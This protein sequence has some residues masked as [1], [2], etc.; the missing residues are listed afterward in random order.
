MLNKTPPVPTFITTVDEWVLALAHPDITSLQARELYGCY[1]EEES[2]GQLSPA[3]LTH[4]WPS[5]DDIEWRMF[6]ARIVQDSLATYMSRDDHE[7]YMHGET[8][9][10]DVVQSCAMFWPIF[11]QCADYMDFEYIPRSGRYAYPDRFKQLRGL[12][13]QVQVDPDESLLCKLATGTH[14]STDI[15]GAVL[16]LLD[17]ELIWSLPTTVLHELFDAA[18]KDNRFELGSENDLWLCQALSRNSNNVIEA[19]YCDAASKEYENVGPVFQRVKLITQYALENRY[20]RYMA[21]GL[22]SSMMAGN[23]PDKH[24]C[25]LRKFMKD[26]ALHHDSDALLH[27]AQVTECASEPIRSVWFV[28]IDSNVA[29]RNLND[30][31]S[32]LIPEY[33]K[34]NVA[35]DALGLTRREQLNSCLLLRSSQQELG[36]KNLPG[37]L[38]V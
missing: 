19:F 17:W 36:V 9:T 32:L 25:V 38:S 2:I 28:L 8:S 15:V 34:N 26:L 1:F 31:W 16:D 12:L 33:A 14:E 37:D 5:F 27:L 24:E 22:V 30:T 11:K 35:W 29:G 6:F 18:V 4:L 23:W 21:Y 3:I 10:Y 20:W 13:G 7:I